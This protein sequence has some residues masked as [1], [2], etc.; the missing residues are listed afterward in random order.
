MR[1]WTVLS[2]LVIAG[3]VTADPPKTEAT[4]PVEV[5]LDGLTSAVPQSW[6][7]EKP[8]NSGRSYQFKLPRTNGDKEDG[9]IFVLPTVHGTAH[10]NI[11]MLKGL[12][13]LST[14]MTKTEALH[15]WEFKNAKA[16]LTCLDIQGTFRVKDKPL[17]D[18]LKEVHPDY[19]MIAA[20]WVSKDA[21]YSIRMFGPR[22]TLDGHAKEFE[23][24]LRN[25]K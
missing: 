3:V 11:E 21:S 2:L 25:F 1:I 14:S 16:T 4:K 7:A 24:W 18:S 12:F 20:V 9:M 6:K 8:S 19:R 15:E 5:T 22:K 17:D 23:Q 13:I 10:E